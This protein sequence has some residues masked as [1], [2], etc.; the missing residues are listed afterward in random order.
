MA[1]V[2]IKCNHCDRSTGLILKFKTVK[3]MGTKFVLNT[4]CHRVGL[5]WKISSSKQMK[6]DTKENSNP[7]WLN[8][9]PRYY[10]AKILGL[11]SFIRIMK[12]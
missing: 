2:F 7:N 9:V 8:N 3:E 4:K 6:Y 1:S 11:N 5:S 12:F 10:T